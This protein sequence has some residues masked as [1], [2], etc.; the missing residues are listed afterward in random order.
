MSDSFTCLYCGYEKQHAEASL[1]HAI[2]QF[3][4]GECAPA[5]FQ[6]TNVCNT[7]NNNLGLW[8]DAC[9]AKS[10]FITN[11][12]AEAARSLCTKVDDPGLPLRYIGKV[13][14]KD[15]YMPN[16]YISEHWIGPSGETVVWVRPH[17]ERMASYAG[18][19][20]ID[21]RKKE[22]VV[23]FFPVSDSEEKFLLGLRSLHR[24]LKKRKV[25]KILAA[26]LV[27]SNGKLV[28][29][30]KL[31][32]NSQTLED[33][34]NCDV[35]RNLI[36]EGN[37]SS[38]VLVDMKFDQRFRC[39]LQLGVGYSLFG[40]DFLNYTSLDEVQNGLWPKRSRENFKIRGASTISLLLN[41]NLLGEMVGYPG[42]VAI[43]VLQS[44]QSWIMS[45]S[46]D[47]KLP[48][49]IE[50]G[51]SSMNS[52]YINQEEGYVLLLFPYREQVIQLTMA[53]LI[54]H[55]YGYRKHPDLDKID[56]IRRAAAQF[57]IQLLTIP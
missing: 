34:K 42:A 25:R 24:A 6:L 10:W 52:L 2:P 48:F 30:E 33:L 39:K 3:M 36:R 8:V 21:T 9:Y 7:C 54:A 46:I 50:L 47:E 53:E 19:N 51:P 17:D 41:N 28:D 49:T 14:I 12:M 22:S 18:G 26:K 55:R 45:L 16:Q 5:I 13:D 27:D 32:F 40:E 37:L 43:V 31:G 44:G 56:I 4:G 1:E 20:P 23:Y 38:K 29:S 11:Y 15:L 57:D 35:I